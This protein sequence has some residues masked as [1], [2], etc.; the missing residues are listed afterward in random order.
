MRKIRFTTII[1]II[2][3]LIIV[4]AGCT[5]EQEIKVIE[6]GS[7]NILKV[8]TLSDICF[9]GSNNDEMRKT[10]IKRLIESQKPEFIVLNGNVVNAVNNGDL[11]RMAGEYIDTFNIPWTV[12]LGEKDIKGNTSKNSICSILTKFDNSY[13]M[14]GE[15]YGEA[16]HILQV[17]NK[18]K[19]ITSLIIMD[20]SQEFTDAQDTWYRNIVAKISD[21]YSTVLGK[22]V[23]T[24]MFM[25]KPIT[26]FKEAAKK[27]G[28]SDHLYGTYR[29]DVTALTN[30]EKFFK[31]I[32]ELGSTKAILSGYDTLNDFAVYY[33]DILFSYVNSMYI[34]ENKEQ[35]AIN[36]GT[37]LYLNGQ[38]S[39]SASQIKYESVKK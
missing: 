33:Y 39:V 1:I 29:T 23:Q 35:T 9:D 32:K 2:T 37:M 36:G 5:P 38:I 28:S 25:N 30:T 19:Y 10:M 26:E 18:N 34:S 7:D 12:A 13:F 16:N 27:I 21:E 15:S 24:I 22:T 3:I 17:K 20:S 11:M 6:S 4:F 14:K 8:L 31:T